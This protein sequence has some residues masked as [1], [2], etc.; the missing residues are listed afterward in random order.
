MSKKSLVTAIAVL[1]AVGAYMGTAT[2]TPRSDLSELQLAN[3]EALADGSEQSATQACY[4]N[5]QAKPG[6]QVCY[7]PICQFIPG[8]PD[9]S[10]EVTTC[11]KN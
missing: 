9:L 10:Y 3:V 4:N 2:L 8:A 5:I 1:L 7:C 11:P 6:C